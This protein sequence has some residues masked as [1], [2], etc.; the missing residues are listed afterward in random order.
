MV[1]SEEPE[2][3]RTN[4]HVKGWHNKINRAARKSHPNIFE[5]VELFQS[6]QAAT[7]VMLQ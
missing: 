7:E 1:G 6:E 5:A 3:P 2:S 4:N